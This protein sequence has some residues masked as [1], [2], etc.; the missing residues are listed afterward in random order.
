MEKRSGEK[1][2]GSEN[3]TPKK[4]RS[5]ARRVAVRESEGGEDPKALV[6]R[7]EPDMLE[8]PLCFAP[9]L[10][11]IFQCK[12]GHPACESCCAR[13]QNKCPTCHEP[14]GDIRCRPLEK[15]IAGMAVPCAFRSKGCKQALKYAEKPTH[16]AVFCQHAPCACPVPGCAYAGLLLHEH[17]RGA[18]SAGAGDD[19]AVSFVREATVT[20]HRSMLFRVLLHPPDSRVFLLLNGGE[21]KSG[22]SLSLLCVGP[23]PAA[24]Q[25]LEYTM[26]VRAGGEPGA[27]SL[28][29]SGTV[30]CTRR[31]PGPGQAPADG[32]LF[33]PDAYWSSSGSVSVTV[34]LRKQAAVEKPA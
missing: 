19:A 17:I 5:T 33:V 26:V 32:F 7:L 22:R 25:E 1:A 6:V 24:G 21:I 20:L 10:A 18:H 30:P 14:I 23:R 27:L 28:S 8:C 4:L 15:L 13:V 16:E 29:A 12:S 31:W 9:F 11:S 2:M 34:H 3:G